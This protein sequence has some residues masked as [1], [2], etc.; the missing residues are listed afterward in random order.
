VHEQKFRKGKKMKIKI[1]IITLLLATI[2]L[3]ACGTKAPEVEQPQPG[4]EVTYEPVKVTINSSRQINFAPI[5]FAEA[6]GYFDEYGIE[7]EVI[8]FQVI[9]EAVPLL[10]SGDLDVY[11]GPITSGLFN[12]LGQEEA[13]KVVAGRGTSTPGTCNF[14][15]ILVRKELFDSGAVT[16]PADFAGLRVAGRTNDIHGYFMDIY[17]EGTGLTLDDLQWIDMP[18]PV[19]VD[20]FSNDAAD[21]ILAPEITL[22]YIKEQGQSVT[23]TSVEDLIGV[24]Q[25]SVLTFG[26]RLTTGDPDIGNRFMAAYLKG[27]QQ[28]NLGKTEENLDLMVEATGDS[29]EMLEAACWIP[30]MAD[31]SL[32]WESLDAYQQW[33]VMMGFQDAAITEDQFWTSKFIDAANEMLGQ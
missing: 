27:V 24:F 1:T 19:M 25:S 33:N 10:I 32:D 22:S 17:L 7:L 23:L 5:F 31:G 14:S 4:E 28:Y 15:E 3:G 2:I 26:R 12:I 21:I 18:L 13:V 16:S 8:P 29:R 20:V 6:L 9:F 30:I 11:A